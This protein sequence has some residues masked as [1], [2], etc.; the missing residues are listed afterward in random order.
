[1]VILENPSVCRRI[2]TFSRDHKG[3]LWWMFNSSAIVFFFTNILI[4]TMCTMEKSQSLRIC[5]THV[6]LLH[7]IVHHQT[8]SATAILRWKC[9]LLFGH[10]VQHLP[11]SGQVISPLSFIKRSPPAHT[12]LVLPSRWESPTVCHPLVYVSL[13]SQNVS[14]VSEADCSRWWHGNFPACLLTCRFSL[15]PRQDVKRKCFIKI[16]PTR[17]AA[18]TYWCITV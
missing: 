3:S 8:S 12:L 4:I 7:C 15:S 10:R 11:L 2:N 1:M 6:F 13:F 5:S 16:L 14:Y 18:V 17:R 9:M